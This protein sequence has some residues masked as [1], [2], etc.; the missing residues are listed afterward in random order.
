L[1][2]NA[3]QQA[4]SLT[5]ITAG[6]GESQPLGVAATSNSPDL[7]PDLSVQYSSPQADGTLTFTPA[8]NRSGVAYVTVTV[9]DG[10]LDGRLDTEGDNASLAQKF[11]VIVNAVNP[12]TL[13]AIGNPPRVNQDA[14]E[15][16]VG[17]S[18]ITT[19]G[20]ADAELAVT[21]S[22]DNTALI[23]ALRVAYTAPAET[24]TVFYTPSPGQSGTA[25]IT[26]TVTHGGTDRR[27]ATPEDNKSFSRSFTVT[28]NGAP[29]DIVL[30]AAPIAENSAG[31]V[32]GSVVVHD[33]DVSDTHSFFI[34]DAR[35]EIAGGQ[36]RLRADQA[37]D[38]EAGATVPVRI[39]A[40]DPGG[41]S[42]S[43]DFALMVLDVNERPQIVQPI[44]DQQAVENIALLF[45]VPAETFVDPDAG[46]HVTYAAQL[47]AGGE[48]PGWLQFDAATCTF[49][50]TPP[51]GAAG[52][53]T[54]QVTARD[55]DGLE[56]IAAFRLTVSV[57][58][59]PWQNPVNAL[60]V[61]A[62]GR[63]IPLDVLLTINY[64][65]VYGIGRPPVLPSPH[66]SVRY[67]DV[68]GDNVVSPVD[69][70]R[71]INY[72]NA[73]SA[74]GGE[75]EAA[76]GL[77]NSRDAFPA[78]G[79]GLP[80]PAQGSSA[81]PRAELPSWDDAL[82]VLAEDVARAYAALESSRRWDGLW[83]IA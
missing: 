12:P 38:R 11:T 7:L 41:L 36:L 82:D 44:P 32:V 24:A 83:D 27:L 40:T 64:I 28:V 77:A 46:D 57:N 33:P 19:G 30:T 69:V 6:G 50:G 10:G 26:V 62:D 42:V 65:N 8:P 63:V 18:G 75:G 52:P 35:F 47:S 14:G 78:L 58:S 55:R 1:E 66:G 61:D 39:T 37:L 67:F 43:R 45:T 31:A 56:A 4:V 3:P 74:G 73:R 25:Q 59:C 21:A 79:R 48:L 9:T 51:F 17:L 22:T 49:S 60:D 76:G 70:L 15:Q 13:D 53:L 16:S 80:T 72:I 71:V 68:S 23:T 2:E 29:T 34:S 81:R 54:L 20:Q 5:G